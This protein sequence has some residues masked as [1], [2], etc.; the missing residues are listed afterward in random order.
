MI[1]L[2]GKSNIKAIEKKLDAKAK[3]IAWGQ[4]NAVKVE[5]FSL[6]QT[7]R[8][9]ILL[10]RPAP[11]VRWPD[12]S[13]IARTLNRRTGV[14]Q[15]IALKQ[16]AAGVTYE[17]DPLAAATMRIGFTRRSPRWAVRTATMQQ[18]GFT[19]PVTP[20]LRLMML[21]KGTQ[22][23]FSRSWRGRRTGNPLILKRT[24]TRLV[25]PPRPIISPFWAAEKDKSAVR[26]RRNFKLIMRGRTAPGGVLYSAQ[27]MATWG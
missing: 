7:L 23:R 13:M 26:I 2:I 19:R 17:V 9:A 20:M 10:G 18:R 25:T 5:A 3:D 14:R 27:D 8:Q 11:G 21:R 1:Q 12:L 22:R 6:R 4:V 15:P 24:T 16:L